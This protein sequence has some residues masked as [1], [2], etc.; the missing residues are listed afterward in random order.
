M[1]VDLSRL[2]QLR[3]PLNHVCWFSINIHESGKLSIAAD[4]E[5]LRYLHFILLPSD[6]DFLGS[7]CGSFGRATIQEVRGSNPAIGKIQNELLNCSKDVVKKTSP[8][9][10]HF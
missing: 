8:R 3:G 6:I 10:A 4:N 2:P 9:I 1:E 5:F 7:G